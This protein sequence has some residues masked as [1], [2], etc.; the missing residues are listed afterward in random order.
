[1]DDNTGEGAFAVLCFFSFQLAGAVP[2]LVPR[3]R[4]RPVIGVSICV[5]AFV[6]GSRSCFLNR[7][8]TGLMELEHLKTWGLEL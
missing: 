5:F 7:R 8:E 6:N 1:M 3:Q 2:G 4:R